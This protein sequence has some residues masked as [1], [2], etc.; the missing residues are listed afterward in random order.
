MTD[1]FL[2]IDASKG[3]S[4]FVILDSSKRCVEDDFQLD[5]TFDGHQKLYNILSEFCVRHPKANIFAAVESTGG[6]EN[7]WFGTLARFQ[8]HLPIK[9]SRLN[10][11]GVYNNSKAELNRNITDKISA[12]NISKYMI[13]HPEK[14]Q[15]QQQDTLSSLRKQWGFI[16]MLKKQKTQLLNQLESNLYTANPEILAYC[17]DSTPAWVLS[18]LQRY[19]TALK[20]ARAKKSSV[21]LIPYVTPQKA[22]KLIDSA[23]C[24]VA[25]ATDETASQIIKA[26][27]QQIRQLSKT[28]NAQTKAMADKCSIPEV[29][30]L[31][32]FIG[33]GDDSA[34]GLILEVGSI[35]RFESAKHLASFF[36]LHPVYK[37]SG[38]GSWGY[39]MS[40]KGRVA[41]RQILYMVAMVAIQ[42]N[43]LIR[44][45][46]EKHTE[47]GMKKKAALGVCMH[48]IIRII[49]GML[50]HNK[51]FNPE[52]DRN[53]RE[54][55][56]SQG[57]KKVCRDKSRRYQ[58]YDVIAPISRRQAKKREERKQ[59]QS[60]NIAKCGIKAPVHVS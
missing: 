18:L 4:N 57:E 33:I 37:K 41:P 53:N 58:A 5:D 24:S 2:G 38:D 31:K 23:K 39:H 55:Q 32:T 6:Y 51:P 56:N 60:D 14:I 40:K 1:F 52:I 36:G 21:A 50:K 9:S 35:E 26:A 44:E 30:L 11:C 34:V 48:K 7:N 12:E 8:E 43:V 27:V 59:S 28:I 45:I 3:Y 13:E 54:K 19:P 47:K 20:L 15:Y 46:Y 25:S 49:Y 17:K 29:D 42:S 16:K 22:Q 10:P